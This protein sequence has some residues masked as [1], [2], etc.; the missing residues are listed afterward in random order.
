MRKII[1]VKIFQD[2]EDKNEVLSNKRKVS[3]S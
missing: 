3:L 1:S 2:E